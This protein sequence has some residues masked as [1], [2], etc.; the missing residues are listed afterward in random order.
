MH[1]SEYFI[2]LDSDLQ[3]LMCCFVKPHVLTYQRKPPPIR[4]PVWCAVTRRRM[5]VDGLLEWREEA[6]SSGASTGRSPGVTATKLSVHCHHRPSLES[7]LGLTFTPAWFHHCWGVCTSLKS[8][9]NGSGYCV[10]LLELPGVGV[11]TNLRQKREPQL[12]SSSFFV[13][14][15]YLW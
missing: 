9:A 2:F 7:V 12:T 8:A 13:H 15:C 11:L 5:F 10:G 1:F 6:V 3:S 4:G 14:F